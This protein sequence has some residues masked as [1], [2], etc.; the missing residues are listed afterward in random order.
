M[1]VW[2][3]LAVIIDGLYGNT[4]Y[5]RLA[6]RRSTRRAAAIVTTVHSIEYV[7]FEAQR[8]DGVPP[9]SMEHAVMKR[10][11]RWCFKQQEAD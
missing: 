11:S 3:A 5:S 10:K 8:L 4:D 7:C 6:S 1:P 2:Y 9:Y